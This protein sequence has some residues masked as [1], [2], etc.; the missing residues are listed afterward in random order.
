MSAAAASKP[1]LAV[2]A[3]EKVKTGVWFLQRPAYWEHAAALV[4]RKVAEDHDTS[5]LRTAA[6]EWAAHRS[7]T[8]EA[9]LRKVGLLPDGHAAP[10]LPQSILDDAEA[11]VRASG[12]SMGGAGDVQL[13]YA[14]TFLSKAEAVIESG[15][16]YGWSSLAILS[17]FD[18]RTG[19]RLVSVDMPYPK[20]GHEAHVG[21]VVPEAL[22]GGWVLIREPDRRGLEKA[23]EALGV[24][25]DLVHYDSDKSFWGRKY[26]FE[27][28]WAALR[29]G[30]VFISDDIQDNFAF[31]DFVEALGLEFGVTSYLGKYVGILRKPDPLSS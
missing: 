4:A 12:V 20:M 1:P 19:A 7:D 27:V 3:F 29:P 17:A 10:S 5:F 8:V 11:Q 25:A 26:G 2:R 13:L 21:T 14:A 9:A 24:S 30:G 15:V 18:G 22:R 31:R 23:V 28:M 6:T 16:A